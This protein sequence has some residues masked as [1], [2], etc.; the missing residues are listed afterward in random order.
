[1]LLNSAVRFHG[2][3]ATTEQI[4]KVFLKEGITFHSAVGTAYSDNAALLRQQSQIRQCV[5]DT[6]EKLI[7]EAFKNSLSI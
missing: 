7:T 5:P 1:V 2:I 3:V 6:A 4:S